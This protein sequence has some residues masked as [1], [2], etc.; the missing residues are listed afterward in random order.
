M[1]G[2]TLVKKMANLPYPLLVIQLR[3]ERQARCPSPL[4]VPCQS[5]TSLGGMNK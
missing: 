3:K 2:D 5:A 4:L 1:F